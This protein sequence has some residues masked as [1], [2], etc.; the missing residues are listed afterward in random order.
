MLAALVQ[1]VEVGDK[2]TYDEIR[3]TPVHYCLCLGEL[4]LVMSIFLVATRK[5][6]GEYICPTINVK[7]EYHFLHMMKT[8]G[9]TDLIQKEITRR[10]IFSGKR[11][12]TAG[13]NNGINIF[14]PS[15]LDKCLSQTPK[16]VIKTK[17]DARVGNVFFIGGRKRKDCFGHFLDHY[18][19]STK[20]FAWF[21]FCTSR[22]PEL[23]GI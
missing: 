12:C 8:P 1:A 20:N 11:F 9:D 16:A 4:G 10:R 22:K 13:N 3:K 21:P 5:A 15:F 23:T 14:K 2:T 6:L 17:K 18:A 7:N 19:S